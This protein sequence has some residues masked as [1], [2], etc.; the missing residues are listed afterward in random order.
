MATVLSLDGV[1]VVPYLVLDSYS[2]QTSL[3]G[4]GEEFTAAN[5]DIVGGEQGFKVALSFSLK[6]VP[7]ALAQRISHILKGG[8]F[9]CSYSAPDE[10]TTDFIAESCKATPKNKATMWD[11]DVTVKSKSLICSGDRL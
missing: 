9:S 6:S 7:L 3:E 4:G 1:N 5:G 10:F 11:F 8:S 2:V